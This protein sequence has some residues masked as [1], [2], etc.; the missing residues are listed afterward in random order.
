MPSTPPTT[1]L[2]TV[3]KYSLTSHYI[4]S[5]KA[6]SCQRIA[7]CPLIFICKILKIEAS[8]G[9]IRTFISV[10]FAVISRSY[11]R[12]LPLK[13]HRFYPAR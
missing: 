11:T 3:S 2:I 6:S 1:G 8:G 10:N 4:L 5:L 13:L 12:V 7:P 9:K